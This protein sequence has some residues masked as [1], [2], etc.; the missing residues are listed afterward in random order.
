MDKL[1]LLACP[2]SLPNTFTKNGDN[3]RDAFE[4]GRSFKREEKKT[5]LNVSYRRRY[6]KEYITLKNVIRVSL[7][8][9]KYWIYREGTNVT[10]FKRND[11]DYL[12]IDIVEEEKTDETTKLPRT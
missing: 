11:I 4:L 8:L 2:K 6:E 12:G 5:L 9:D 3:I 7:L 1:H 10:K